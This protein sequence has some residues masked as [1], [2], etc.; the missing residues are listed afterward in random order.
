MWAGGG[1]SWW[2]WAVCAGSILIY[3]V[4]VACGGSVRSGLWHRLNAE[5]Y[6]YRHE[7]N[8]D[9]ARM[10]G[11]CVDGA[12]VGCGRRVWAVPLRGRCDYA[13]LGSRLL[14]SGRGANACIG[15]WHGLSGESASGSQLKG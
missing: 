8:V 7:V 10:G 12:H 5:W 11:V 15:L 6:S 9:G 2:G 4:L 13:R 14:C 1:L 3:R